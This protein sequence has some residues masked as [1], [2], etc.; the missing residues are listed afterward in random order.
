MT[1]EPI[2]TS[3][4]IRKEALII[5]GYKDGKIPKIDYTTC[6]PIKEKKEG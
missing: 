4:K 1:R 6:C 5:L 2:T 3:G